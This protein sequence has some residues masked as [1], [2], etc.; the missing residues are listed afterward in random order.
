MV[1]SRYIRVTK[2]PI[3][4]KNI[5]MVVGHDRTW[6]KGENIIERFPRQAPH[7]IK[8][9]RNIGFNYRCKGKCGR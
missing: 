7:Y 2:N 1:T 5:A 3:R 9:I 6:V 8:H 4:G